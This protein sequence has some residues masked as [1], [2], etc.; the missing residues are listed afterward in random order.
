M[1]FSTDDEGGL[2]PQVSDVPGAYGIGVVYLRV[3]IRIVGLRYR[4]EGDAGL[5]GCGG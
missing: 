4:T 1:K 5:V 3:E 2:C